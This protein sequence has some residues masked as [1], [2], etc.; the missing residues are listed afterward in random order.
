MLLHQSISQKNTAGA[1]TR[2]GATTITTFGRQKI[3]HNIIGKDE[4]A[5]LNKCTTRANPL[6][7]LG[8]QSGQ[9]LI[10]SYKLID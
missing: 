1:Q 6:G 5:K 2:A 3:C 7:T 10:R 4:T 9:R 8:T